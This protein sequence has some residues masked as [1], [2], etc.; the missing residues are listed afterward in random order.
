MINKAFAPTGRLVDCYIYP[1]RCPGL[2]A[3]GPSARTFN[4]RNLSNL[5]GSN[6]ILFDIFIVCLRKLLPLVG[7][8]TFC[9]QCSMGFTIFY[10][11]YEVIP[12]ASVG[13]SI[14]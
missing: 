4:V 13:S 7:K 10:Y 12:Y 2:G 8:I 11:E 3:S 1:G 14:L 5:I 9:Y 6:F